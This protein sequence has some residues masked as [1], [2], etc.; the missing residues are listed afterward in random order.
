MIPAQAPYEGEG[1]HDAQGLL[2]R[3]VVEECTGR[4]TLRRQ[5]VETR[6]L[7]PRKCEVAPLLH[8]GAVQE[9]AWDFTTKP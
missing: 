2:L 8:N 5:R 6:I 1:A 3:R 9:S 7:S 4:I